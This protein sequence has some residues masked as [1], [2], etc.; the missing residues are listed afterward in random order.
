MDPPPVL[1]VLGLT[2]LAASRMRREGEVR[3]TNYYLRLAELLALDDGQVEPLRD[4]LSQ[5][6][7]LRV[8]EM[9]RALG[10]WIE[11]QDG[12]VGLSTIPATARPERIGYPLS[13]ALIR[14]SDRVQL[15]RFFAAMDLRD[16]E[17]PSDE[18][19]GYSLKIWSQ[20]QRL[21]EAL[22]TAI[23]DDALRV[24]VVSI[25][26]VIA[27]SWDG[28]VLSEEGTPRLDLRLAVDLDAW[29]AQ[30]IIQ[31]PETEGNPA[32]S[33]TVLVGRALDEALARGL[34]Y[35]I[36]SGMGVF[37]PSEVLIFRRSPITGTWVS[38]SE[39]FDPFDEHLVAVT[40][41]IQRRAD[42]F[43]HAAARQ[44]WKIVRQD[45]ERALLPGRILY[46]RVQLMGE[47]QLTS[48]LEALPE[49]SR[50]AF[51]PRT[52]AR[53]RLVNGLPVLGGL[54]TAVYLMGGEPD[55]ALPYSGERVL[56]AVTLDGRSDLLYSTG[57]PIELRRF[58]LAEGQHE[59][60]V[61]GYS[62]R[63][64]TVRPSA[65]LAPFSTT[66]GLGWLADAQLV[67][68][69]LAEQVARGAYVRGARPG[70]SVAV[71]RGAESTWWLMN[72]GRSHPEAEPPLPSFILRAG[73][74]AS[75]DEFYEVD[76]PTEAAWL[77]QRF[78]GAW[79]VR[80]VRTG[81]PEILVKFDPSEMWSRVHRQ[82][83]ASQEWAFLL[84]VGE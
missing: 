72:G 44:G 23:G 55:L 1:P 25:V 40:P 76:P 69:P 64:Q 9:W 68:R 43:M 18:A 35:E 33:E 16:R 80:A 7:F 73:V 48:A 65:V 47:A 12:R 37:A 17:L 79:R 83:G 10:E 45:P 14:A 36:S 51:A 60:T 2:V 74:D 84:G 50:R 13:Q 59:V 46:E 28:T 57:F 82:D 34:R 8:V 67:V 62:I 39:G 63:F 53:P 30:W 6:A 75:V 70:T 26:R 41:D 78:R 27:M 22:R 49:G 4:V 24:V 15:T 11:Q 56:S 38:S 20:R 52:V 66:D 31:H 21:S 3:S 81:E 61:D 19:L 54:S 42:T 58:E 71:R 32:F 77:A 29:T 5:R